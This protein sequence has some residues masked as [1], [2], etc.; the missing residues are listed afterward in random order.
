MRTTHYVLFAIAVVTFGYVAAAPGQAALQEEGASAIPPDPALT[1]E[2]KAEHD[3]WPAEKQAA[4][5]AWPGETKGY[6]WTLSDERRMM[7]WALAD[8]DTIALTAMTGPER[9]AAWERIEALAGAPPTASSS[10]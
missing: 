7:F 8:S 2:Q 5:A 3:G 6:Y 10:L 4:Y 1:P 9:E